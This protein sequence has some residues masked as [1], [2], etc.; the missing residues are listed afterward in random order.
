M[1]D[2]RQ[3]FLSLP[4]TV[5]IT[6]VYWYILDFNR[7]APFDKLKKGEITIEEATAIAK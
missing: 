1:N 5:V 7:A 4:D 3:A 2:M 6:D